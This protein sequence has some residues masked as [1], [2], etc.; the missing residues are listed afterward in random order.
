MMNVTG[1]V[2][3]RRNSVAA[4]PAR[5]PFVVRQVKKDGTP[6]SRRPHPYDYHTNEESARNYIAHLKLTDHAIF[7]N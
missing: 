2:S 3:A 4:N 5:F 1:M 6:S 7:K